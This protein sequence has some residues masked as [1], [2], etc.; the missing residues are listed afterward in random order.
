MQETSSSRKCV[1]LQTFTTNTSLSHVMKYNMWLCNGCVR[2]SIMEWVIFFRLNMI[3]TCSSNS[4]WIW[5][6]WCIISCTPFVDI[7]Q[8]SKCK[9]S[10]KLSIVMHVNKIDVNNKPF[11]ILVINK[12]VNNTVVLTLNPAAPENGI[13][14]S[15][16]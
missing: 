14:F 11:F 16:P 13:I 12:I 1:N 10:T 9:N 2:I 7:V 8:I 4:H 5:W 3:L 6:H 15:L